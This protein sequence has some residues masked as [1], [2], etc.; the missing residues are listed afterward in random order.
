MTEPMKGILAMAA[1]C[2]I[3]GLSPIFYAQVSHVPPLEVLSYR[4]LWSLIFFAAVLALQGRFGH[5]AATL[6]RPA[7]VW[8]LALAAG[9]IATNWFLFIYSVGQGHVTESSL[10]YYIFPLAAVL[11]GRLVLGERLAR[12]QWIAV[13]LATLAVVILTVGLQAAP[14]IAIA[15]ASTFA[16]YGLIKKGLD[17]GPVLSVTVEML[18]LSPLAVVWIVL[19]GTG[20]GGGNSL[21]THL[22][23]ALSGPLTATPLIMFSYA[24]R[25]VRLST[26]G[27]L[28]YINPTLQFLCAAVY[29]AEPFTPWHAVAFPIIWVALALYSVASLGQERA[30]RR[31]ASAAGT[32]A[33]RVT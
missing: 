8:K 32:S 28:Q 13:A 5:M 31:A 25:R 30:A 20:V 16:G 1:A 21:T 11:L 29:F 6:R 26:I 9:F 18:I 10:G 24:A 22:V 23:L 4:T 19:W 14:F 3:W 15:I 12:L 33:A 17:L 27:L 7:I 2:L